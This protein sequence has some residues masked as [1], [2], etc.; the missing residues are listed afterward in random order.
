VFFRREETQSINRLYAL[1]NSFSYPEISRSLLGE[2]PEG[3]SLARNLL[4]DCPSAIDV[5]VLMNEQLE[6]TQHHIEVKIEDL[7][8]ICLVHPK[9]AL[10]WLSIPGI[11]LIN[12][13]TLIAYI[14]DGSRFSN[15][16]QSL[17]YAGL[18]PK[19]DQNSFVDKHLGI[20]HRGN[21]YIRRNIVQGVG[22]SRR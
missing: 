21:A 5:E 10:L 3:R 7:R 18:I 15:P 6:L 12:A 16:H 9:Q 20:T 11:G 4:S 19:Q 1:Y 8:N 2:Q 14:G 17:N 13:A 22:P